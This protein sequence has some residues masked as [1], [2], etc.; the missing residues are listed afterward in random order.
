[1]QHEYESDYLTVINGENPFNSAAPSTIDAAITTPEALTTE[2]YAASMQKANR[3]FNNLQLANQAVSLATNSNT[4]ILSGR[5]VVFTDTT[6]NET[7]KNIIALK[8]KFKACA[9]NGSVNNSS[10]QNCLFTDSTFSSSV[11]NTDFHKSSFINASFSELENVNFTNSTCTNTKF[12]GDISG[13]TC[14]AG[15]D[16]AQA[17]FNGAISDTVIFIGANYNSATIPPGGIKTVAELKEKMP[18]MSNDDVVKLN[19]ILSQAHK[20]LFA[21][22]QSNAAKGIAHHINHTHVDA[23]NQAIIATEDEMAQRNVMSHSGLN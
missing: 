17:E 8:A 20:S 5:K 6:F 1:M 10:L 22:Q 12:N 2:L 19:K 16:L 18:D 9:F 15:A 14:F 23:V 11:Q 21:E 13:L 4:I 7:V 3:V